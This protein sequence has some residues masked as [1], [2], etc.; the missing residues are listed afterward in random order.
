MIKINTTNEL[1]KLLKDMD[2][3]HSN[4]QSIFN[5]TINGKYCLPIDI[6]DTNEQINLIKLI[7]KNGYSL[8]W[9]QY[10]YIIRY[11]T[12]NNP[13][14]LCAIIQQGC[15]YS[16]KSLFYNVCLNHK[17]G[18]RLWFNFYVA[19]YK[20]L[21]EILFQ[22]DMLCKARLEHRPDKYFNMLINE[23]INYKKYINTEFVS[24]ENILKYYKKN[25]DII[26]E[27]EYE[28]Y[29]INNR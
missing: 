18:N 17:F 9:L 27:A 24:K 4:A 16:N 14:I 13:V 15:I 8:N 10:A 26:C 29:N 2:A 25:D 21:H 23:L 11:L 22:Q 7:V 3:N 28:F 20:Y 19:H 1:L 5:Q 6:N 12:L